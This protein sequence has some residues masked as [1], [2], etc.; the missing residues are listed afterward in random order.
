MTAGELNYVSFHA[1]FPIQSR[2]R[3]AWIDSDS[4]LGARLIT[5]ALGVNQR[6]VRV[7]MREG[8]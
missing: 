3:N 2:K 1:G 4:A 5:G 8:R 6:F 7:K